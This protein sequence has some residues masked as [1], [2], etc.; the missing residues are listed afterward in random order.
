MHHL[1]MKLC[2]DVCR[3]LARNSRATTPQVGSVLWHPDQRTII[4]LGCNSAPEAEHTREADGNTMVHAEQQVLRQVWFWTSRKCHL[5]ITHAPCRTCA[6]QIVWK[7]VKTVY[8]LDNYGEPSGIA[9]LR[10]HGVQ[11][12][13]LL[14]P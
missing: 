10:K 11:V 13:R 5:F 4:S 7:G 14:A 2:V 12:I 8:Y 9:L 1:D 6:H 3:L